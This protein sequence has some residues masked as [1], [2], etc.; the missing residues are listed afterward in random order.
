MTG[1][2]HERIVSPMTG[3]RGLGAL[4][5]CLAL[6]LAGCGGTADAGVSA[7]RVPTHTVYDS[8]TE[9][10]IMGTI[11]VDPRRLLPAEIPRRHAV[12]RLPTQGGLDDGRHAHGAGT[13]LPGR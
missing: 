6:G 12:R 13:C 3:R 4:G 8:G 2:S 9:A 7:L 5:S 1:W 11:E 10:W